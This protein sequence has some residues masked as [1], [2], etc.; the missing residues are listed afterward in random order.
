MIIPSRWFNGGKGLD[1]FR[2]NMLGDRHITCL[3]D[4]KNA[5]ECF[6]GISLGGGV[7]YFL[8]EKNRT[9]DCNVVNIID[10]IRIALTR[11]L[12]AF[13]VFVRYNNA[14]KKGWRRL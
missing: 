9:S 11:K 12:D 8:W 6:P 3:I 5:K 14:V 2:K 1:K 4:Y 7:C 10:G 13:P